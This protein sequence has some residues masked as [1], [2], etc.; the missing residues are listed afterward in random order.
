MRMPIDA[1]NGD[2]PPS[3]NGPSPAAPAEES[4]AWAARKL[5]RAARAATLATSASGQPFASLVTP[6]CAADGSVL[7][8]LSDLSEHTRHLRA[9]PRCALLVTG[10]TTEQ[11]PQTA[12]RITITGLAEPSTD[13]A[14]KARWLAIHPYAAFY[15]DFSDFSV[16][17]VAPLSGLFVGGFARA[18]RLR[19]ADLVPD[20]AAAAAVAGAAERIL[21]H[22]NADHAGAIG[23]LADPMDPDGW[24]MVG[25]DTDGFDLARGGRVVRIAFGTPVADAGAVRAE[26]V[27]MVAAA[28]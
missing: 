5:L 18:N 26:L 2:P 7:M 13:P 15:A 28:G 22:C 27:R 16:W 14:L 8:L 24:V 9:D 19:G 10:T 11:N 1:T 23:K 12:P 6:A 3:R 20:A 4:P 17:R 25:V 21:G